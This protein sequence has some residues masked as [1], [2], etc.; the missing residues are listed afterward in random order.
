MSSSLHGSVL[1]AG[2][3]RIVSWR[4]RCLYQSARESQTPGPAV[5]RAARPPS[6]ANAKGG[7]RDTPDPFEFDDRV[8]EI[9]RHGAHMAH[10]GGEDVGQFFDVR[11]WPVRAGGI[12]DAPR[13]RLARTGPA[14][15]SAVTRSGGTGGSFCRRSTRAAWASSPRVH[16]ERDA[17][18]G[19]APG[20]ATSSGRVSRGTPRI[21][22]I[23]DGRKPGA[24]LPDAR[25]AARPHSCGGSR[26]ANR[27]RRP[28][29]CRADR[30]PRGCPPLSARGSSC[31]GA[32]T[33]IVPAFVGPGRQSI[34]ERPREAEGA[35]SRYR[36]SS[37]SAKARGRGQASQLSRA[38]LSRSAAS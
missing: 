1:F 22:P 20:R 31:A 30:S 25:R 21:A 17:R 9:L 26:S 34:D 37:A 10:G 32:S 7:C 16:P 19:P 18:T 14:S 33:R 27:Q 11:L 2:K 23:I 36:L 12:R 35:G 5:V 29:R 38:S 13:T 4:V 6:P 3:I 8:Q 24:N 15:V 28:R